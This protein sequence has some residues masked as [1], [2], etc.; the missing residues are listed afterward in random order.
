MP[1]R[2]PHQ[3]ECLGP[4]MHPANAPSTTSVNRCHQRIDVLVTDETLQH[5][6]IVP[7]DLR[8]ES[9]IGIARENQ[10]CVRRLK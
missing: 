4:R 2:A 1:K 6:K 3:A 7:A 8:Q 5:H 9:E 10:R